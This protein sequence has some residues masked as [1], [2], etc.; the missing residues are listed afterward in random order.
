[1]LRNTGAVIGA[2]ALLLLVIAGGWAFRY[3]TAETR[4]IVN[5]EEQI[6]SAGSRITNYEHFYDLCAAVQGHED[7]LA[8]QRHALANAEGDEAE[9]IRANVAGLEAQR[10]R[11]IRRYNADARK[12]YTRARFLGEDL[13]REISTQEDRTQCAY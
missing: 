13:P 5:A 6:E 4:G 8:A 10:N 11:A 7:A 3:F 9:R 2:I 12:A 1:M